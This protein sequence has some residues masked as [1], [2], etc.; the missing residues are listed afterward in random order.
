MGGNGCGYV[1]PIST[2]VVDPS[3]GNQAS[4]SCFGGDSENNML[5]ATDPNYAGRSVYYPTGIV[6]ENNGYD[7]N[8][9]MMNSV[10]EMS[11][12]SSS[13]VGAPHFTVLNDA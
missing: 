12:R 5:A 1:M 11:Q 3:N 2:M 10:Q 7:P 4:S 6:K 13:N 8:T 9:W